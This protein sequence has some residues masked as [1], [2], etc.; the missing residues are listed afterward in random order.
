[1]YVGLAKETRRRELIR[2]D[3]K[4]CLQTSAIVDPYKSGDA[5]ALIRDGHQISRKEI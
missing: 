3:S 5:G 2:F 4:Y 1:M